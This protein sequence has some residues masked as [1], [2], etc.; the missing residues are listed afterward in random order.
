VLSAVLAIGNFLNQGTR[1]GDAGGFKL[2]S[3][4]AL[5]S[6]RAADKSTT[7]LDV[8]VSTVQKKGGA[9]LT[10]FADDLSLVRVGQ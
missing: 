6:T 9:K 8:L 3:L 10:A 5:T 4:A 7:V 2:D 1:K